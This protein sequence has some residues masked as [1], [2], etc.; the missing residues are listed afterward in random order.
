MSNVSNNMCKR[1]MLSNKQ[2]RNLHDM[3]SI[4]KIRN[5]ANLKDLLR[6]L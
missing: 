3:L 6:A 4:L 1:N 5:F 2:L